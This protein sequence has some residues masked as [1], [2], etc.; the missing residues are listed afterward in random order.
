MKNLLLLAVAVL[1]VTF[2]VGCKS[3][4]GSRE[5]IPG[6]GWVPVGAVE[7]ELPGRV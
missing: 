7:N 3:N 5:F 1:I 6:R 2:S 4:R